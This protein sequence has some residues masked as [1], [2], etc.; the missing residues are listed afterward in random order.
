MYNNIIIFTANIAGPHKFSTGGQTTRVFAFTYNTS[1]LMIQLLHE[2]YWRYLVMN[3][4]PFITKIS[5][6]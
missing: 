2:L 6:G 4:G 1:L 3:P 5:R